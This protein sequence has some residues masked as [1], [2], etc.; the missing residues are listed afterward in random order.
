MGYILVIYVMEFA[1][2]K[3][4]F[5]TLS[6][7]VFFY[8]YFIFLKPLQYLPFLWISMASYMSKNLFTAQCLC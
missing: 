7:H 5:N 3:K 2:Y 4:T 6:Y 8:L 1:Y